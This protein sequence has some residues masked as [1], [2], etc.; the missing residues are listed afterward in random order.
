MD[1]SL[2]TGIAPQMLQMLLMFSE[3]RENACGKLGS[4]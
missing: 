2:L 3:L 4:L 1:F